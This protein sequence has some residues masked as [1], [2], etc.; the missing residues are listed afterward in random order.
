M[1]AYG[2]RMMALESKIE[3]DK[4]FSKKL[5]V[6]AVVCLLFSFGYCFGSVSIANLDKSEVVATN[7]VWIVSILVLVGIY[8]KDVQCIKSYKATEFEIYRLEI[9]DLNTKKEVARITGNKLP[10]YVYDKQIKEPDETISLPNI[11]YGILIG[12]DI[13]I[14]IYLS[15][16]HVV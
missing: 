12:I 8:F 16:I 7:I 4:N 15:V 9:E 14:R 6:L 13:I 10:D 5:K 2:F 11:Y 3:K 1:N